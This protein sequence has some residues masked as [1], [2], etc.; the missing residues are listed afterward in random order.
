[1]KDREREIE[2]V[3]WRKKERKGM[4][5]LLLLS[6]IC[7]S[8]G[9]SGEGVRCPLGVFLC[10]CRCQLIHRKREIERE[11]RDGEEGPRR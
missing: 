7:E 1:M 8:S 9:E 2:C 10:E 5:I 6:V 11:E 3:H 4:E